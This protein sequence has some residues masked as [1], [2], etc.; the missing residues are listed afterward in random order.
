MEFYPKEYPEDKA[1]DYPDILVEFA[2][3]FIDENDSN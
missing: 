2:G 1:A 3:P